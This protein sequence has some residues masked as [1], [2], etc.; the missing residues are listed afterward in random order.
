MFPSGQYFRES[1]NSLYYWFP[2]RG[3][4]EK[5]IKITPGSGETSGK[6][7][8]LQN[9]NMET[10]SRFKG[11]D[12]VIY[13]YTTPPAFLEKTVMVA[14][15]L[16]DRFEQAWQSGWKSYLISVSFCLAI[17]ALWPFGWITRWRL[18]NITLLGISFLII[19]LMNYE[20]NKSVILL[21][22]SEALSQRNS[23]I[24]VLFPV[25][26][27]GFIF[28]FMNLVGGLTAFLRSL[29]T[30]KIGGKK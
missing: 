3:V 11:R 9:P 6:S 2:A 18:L 7:V 28:L 13:T 17:A 26:F 12:N 19:S 16:M 15:S 1:E 5:V 20:L 30:K 27:N 25:I 29:K 23:G 22:I 21:R 10:L 4:P 14:R 8:F 24:A